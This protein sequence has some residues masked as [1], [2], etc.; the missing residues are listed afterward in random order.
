[1]RAGPL[2]D[3]VH[4]CRAASAAIMQMNIDFDPLALGEC[5]EQIELS[6]RITID[7]GRVDAA[8]SK[9]PSRLDSSIS[10]STST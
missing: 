4:L 1:M 3:G 7:P 10:G 9:T 6:R 8:A 2:D 5:E